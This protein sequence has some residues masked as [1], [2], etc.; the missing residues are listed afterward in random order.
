MSTTKQVAS[1][2][3]RDDVAAAAA[4]QLSDA[5]SD[6]Q[7]ST[8]DV[9]TMEPASPEPGNCLIHKNYTN[10]MIHTFAQTQAHTS[11]LIQPLHL[12][13]TNHALWPDCSPQKLLA[14]LTMY[15]PIP[16]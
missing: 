1:K 15:Q 3:R 13:A 16:E 7:H 4:E 10:A 9:P 14:I 6:V 5:V 12:V 2:R 11:L 8:A